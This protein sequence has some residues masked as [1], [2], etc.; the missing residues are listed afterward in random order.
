MDLVNHP[1]FKNPKNG[2][3][4]IISGDPSKQKQVT[5]SQRNYIE[6][7]DLKKECRKCNRYFY[8]F[9]EEQKYWYEE[10]KFSPSA[11]CVFCPECRQAR[12]KVKKLQ[13]EYELLQKNETPSDDKIRRFRIV[14]KTLIKLGCM[15]DRSKIDKLDWKCI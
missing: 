1:R 2:E 13:K 11:D 10:L 15:K 14:A 6:Y 5:W 9:A 3:V 8:F 12:I 4:K 7:A